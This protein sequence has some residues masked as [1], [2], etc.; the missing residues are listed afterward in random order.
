MRIIKPPT[1]LHKSL[2]ISDFT[3]FLGGS[4]E[5]GKA[6]DWQSVLENKLK[7]LNIIVLNPRRD[8]WDS[9]WKQSIKNPQFKEQLN[10][11]LTA[12]EGANIIVMYFDPNTKAP[13]S[14]LELGLFG[15]QGR[16]IVY[17][18]EG[19]WRKGNVDVVCERYGI[20]QVN[21]FGAIVKEIKR[22]LNVRD[23]IA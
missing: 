2:N 10:W 3:V 18:P 11:E 19:F 5:M 1:P 16:T 23:G 4:I 12:L 15:M 13:V 9:S 17:C 21:S 6:K 7:E 14:L 8:N 22:Q 20:K